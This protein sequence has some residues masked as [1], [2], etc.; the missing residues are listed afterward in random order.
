MVVHLSKIHSNQPA[1]FQCMCGFI[2]EDETSLVKHQTNK[3]HKGRIMSDYLV[4]Y[5]TMY[6]EATQNE[7]NRH[8]KERKAWIK[9]R[10][11][12]AGDPMA[13]TLDYRDW[14]STETSE[15]ESWGVVNK[16]LKTAEEENEKLRQR[17]GEL[18]T[19][20]DIMATDLEELAVGV[21]RE[22]ALS[23]FEA[24]WTEQAHDE[25]IQKL[26]HT[27]FP[28]P[29]QRV[30]SAVVVPH[31]NRHLSRNERVWRRSGEAAIR[32]Y[33]ERH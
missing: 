23:G 15:E 17:I 16:K 26:S 8:K 28:H 30:Q 27:L 32:K 4:P 3:N 2:S 10:A 14:E 24:A 22:A 33:N 12:S 18:E 11:S 9:R 25:Y 20:A 7:R 5:D 19:A 29:P 6:R 1:Q 31:T 13:F 21:P